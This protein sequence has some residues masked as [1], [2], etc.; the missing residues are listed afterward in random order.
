MQ[1]GLSQPDE[2]AGTDSA[3]VL[4]APAR[5]RGKPCTHIHTNGVRLVLVME[6]ERMKQFMLKVQHL[7]ISVGNGYDCRD[8][9]PSFIYLTQTRRPMGL[10]WDCRETARGGAR[11]G[12]A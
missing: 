11:G 10:P 3:Q 4:E 5:R 7:R 2:H 1:M 8:L 12:L 6:D 9:L